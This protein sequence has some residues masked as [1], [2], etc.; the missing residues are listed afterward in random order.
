[1]AGAGNVAYAGA[2]VLDPTDVAG[3]GNVAFAGAPVSDPTVWR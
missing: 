1:V 2:P 3:A